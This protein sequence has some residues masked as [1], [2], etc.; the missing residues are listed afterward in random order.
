MPNYVPAGTESARR[1]ASANSPL[2]PHSRS[3]DYSDDSLLVTM[4]RVEQQ[5]AIR[6]HNN[7]IEARKRNKRLRKTGFGTPKKNQ[8]R[9]AQFQAVFNQAENDGE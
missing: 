8:L 5:E 4:Q 9:G 2:H 3:K 7:K 1:I 6:A